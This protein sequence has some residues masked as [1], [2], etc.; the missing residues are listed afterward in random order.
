MAGNTP[1]GGA[2]RNR[3]AQGKADPISD[4][5]RDIVKQMRA[6]YNKKFGN[7]ADAKRATRRRRTA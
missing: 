6:N 2:L 5:E 4:V 7:S 1:S 3:I